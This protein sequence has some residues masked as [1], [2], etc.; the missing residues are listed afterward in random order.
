MLFCPCPLQEAPIWLKSGISWLELERAKL[1]AVNGG[2]FE[3]RRM[4]TAL[5]DTGYEVPS[6]EF[7][8]P[9]YAEDWFPAPPIKCLCHALCKHLVLEECSPPQQTVRRQSFV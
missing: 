7:I 3:H 9:G 8:V 6:G 4:E 5:C 1:W 2:T